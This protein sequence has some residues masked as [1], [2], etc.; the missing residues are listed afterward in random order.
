MA[1]A[2]TTQRPPYRPES[3]HLAGRVFEPACT[4]MHHRPELARM[5]AGLWR[6]A[7]AA[8]KRDGDPR[9]AVVRK[10]SG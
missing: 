6:P 10:M 7:S 8:A 3:R 9:S 4:A 5:P 2:V 1:D